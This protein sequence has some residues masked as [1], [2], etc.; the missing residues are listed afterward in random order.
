MENLYLA[1]GPTPGTNSSHTPAPPSDR[2]GWARP[3]QKLKS[4]VT[5]TPRA[6]GAQTANAVPVAP[7]VSIGRA[8][9]ASPQLLVPSLADQVQVEFAERRQVP[10]RVVL[11]PRLAVDV[12]DFNR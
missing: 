4:P 6:F 5:R 10:V 1:P 8:P 12:G 2:M 3:S 9:S 11:Q 7:P